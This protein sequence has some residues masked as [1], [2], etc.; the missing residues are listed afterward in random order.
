MLA[1]K[2]KKKVMCIVGT[3]P[4]AIKM[5]PVI[6]E[7]C[8]D[9]FFQPMV[10]ATG[11]HTHMLYQALSYFDIKPDFDLGIMKEKQT[12]DH[13]TS[14]VIEGTGKIFDEINP[15]VVLV[16]GDTTTTFAA[17][18]AAF[19]RHIQI[20]HVEAGLRSHNINSPFPEEANRILTDQICSLWFPPTKEAGLN[21]LKEGFDQERIF[22]TGNTV[23]D[24]LNMTIERSQNQKVFVSDDKKVPEDAEVILMTI[25]RRENWGNP[26]RNLC[27][28]VKRILQENEN[29]WLILPVHKNPSVRADI[30]EI[31]QDVQRVILT[32]PLNYPDFVKAMNRSR[33]II[34]DSG[35]VQEEGTSL[36][37]PVLVTRE[38]S[39]RP[40]AIIE[41][42]A[43]LVGNGVEKLKY[44][45]EKLL[46]DQKY[47]NNI[48]S[49]AKMPFGDGRASKRICSRLKELL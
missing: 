42:T 45:V 17:A 41:G 2:S 4:E 32:E 47:Y 13:I 28:T 37:I 18:L 22:I 3:R 46:F 10:L 44:E 8:R 40:E 7:L 26:L 35:G 38:V 48:V 43:M 25:H 23:V 1:D 12:L 29:L 14:K 34:T 24:A 39:E 31:F 49:K 11:Q 6:L 5:A 30:F 21:L 27:N 9:D 19:Y 16:H 15:D 20:G 33:V 36:K